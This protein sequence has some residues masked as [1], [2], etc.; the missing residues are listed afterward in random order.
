MGK[1]VTITE[2]GRTGAVV[3]HEGAKRLSFWWEFGGGDVVAIVNV[4]DEEEWRLKHPW[5]VERR[6]EILG[7]VAAEVVRQKAP[8]CRA[9]IQRDCIYL[10]LE[11]S[12]VG[13]LPPLPSSTPTSARQFDSTKWRSL[14]EKLATAVFIMALLLAGLV[15][16]KNKFL[17]INPG[18]GTPI[19][20][21]VRTDQHL[22]TFIQTLI[23]YTPSLN[24]NHAEDRYRLSLFLVPL[25][26]SQVRMVDLEP[27]PPASSFNLAKVLGSDGRVLWFD[28]G[29]VG[30]VDLKTFKLVRPAD[31]R[32]AVVPSAPPHWPLSPS[33]DTYLSAG[34]QVASNAWFGLHSK[35]EIEGE[36]AQRK[37]LRRVVRAEDAKQ[38]RRFHRG[39]LDPDSTTEYRRILS[40]T[41]VGEAEYLNAAF[42][43]LDDR[44]EPLRLGEPDS[45][46]MIYTS[47][48]GRTGTLVVARVDLSGKILWS[49]DTGMDRFDLQQILPGK[50]A[51]VFVG[52]RPPVPNQVSEPLVVIVE[53][54]TGKMETHSL[55]R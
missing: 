12:T 35:Q 3:Y 34:F 10:R 52:K 16:L 28:V 19:G 45:A 53:N 29:G 42:L 13:G 15:W 49:V 24:R 51:M 43:R 40:M 23:P 31:V 11:T 36:F 8:S 17:V 44:S 46:L 26:G 9:E 14:R 30:G 20:L 5:A 48:P 37:W 33:I 1:I 22:A 27:N 38:L 7:F 39:D 6:A 54:R 55:W 18:K 41:P 4:G 21:T 2:G 32:D 47:D 50:T 25:D